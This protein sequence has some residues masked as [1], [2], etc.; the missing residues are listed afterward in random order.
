MRTRAAQS[1]LAQGG[2]IRRAFRHRLSQL[3]HTKQ[4]IA[5]CLDVRGYDPPADR[6]GGVTFCQAHASEL[7]SLADMARQMGPNARKILAKQFLCPEDITLIGTETKTGM[8]VF[9]TWLS[10]E[11]LGLKVLGDWTLP[12]VASL[13]RIWVAPSRRC[14]GTGTIGCS[15]L[16]KTAA[17]AGA[18][19][20]WSFVRP[21]NTPS[22][23][24]HE[25]LGFSR[26]GQIFLRARFGRKHLIARRNGQEGKR[27]IG[28]QP[29]F[30]TL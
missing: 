13:R 4:W 20:V 8:L 3:W 14:A 28:I 25:K 9:H 30:R 7:D 22:L 6:P 10:H 23:R 5:L 18:S 24:L 16:L 19:Q 27:R 21:D 17:D 11:D 1:T 12:S 2:R 26:T 15:I 29:D